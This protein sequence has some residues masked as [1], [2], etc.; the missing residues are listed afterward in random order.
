VDNVTGFTGGSRVNS[1]MMFITLKPRDER[2]ETAQQV[3]D[4]LRS[5]PKSRG[6]PVFD[7]RSGYPRRRASGQ[8]QL[9]VHPALGRSS[10]PCA[11][12]SRRSAKR[13]PRCRSWRT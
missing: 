9:S 1:G 6:Q 13:W 12:G 5:S 8:R 3:I 2:N 7:G 11:S 10:P 4:R